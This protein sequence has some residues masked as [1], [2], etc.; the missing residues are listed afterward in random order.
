MQHHILA[1]L[2]YAV[3]AC[4]SNDQFLS[5]YS[6]LTGFSIT[7]HTF[8]FNVTPSIYQLRLESIVSLHK[9]SRN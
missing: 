5:S 2:W 9:Y 7:L 3:I 1:A 6:L 8:A 4:V